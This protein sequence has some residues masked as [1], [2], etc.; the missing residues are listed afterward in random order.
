MFWR[1]IFWIVGTGHPL[2][3]IET[4]DL[5]SHTVQALIARAEANEER[6]RGG[7]VAWTYSRDRV[8]ERRELAC[9]SAEQKA[10]R[11][12]RAWADREGNKPNLRMVA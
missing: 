1:L 10:E 8:V 9:E 2:E 6:E 5:D 11:L 12:E 4:V 7:F 3:T